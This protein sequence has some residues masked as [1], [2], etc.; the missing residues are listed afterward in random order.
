MRSPVSLPGTADTSGLET[1]IPPPPEMIVAPDVV[2]P[3]VLPTVPPRP[4]IINPPLGALPVTV[5]WDPAPSA[6]RTMP[7]VVDPMIDPASK[8]DPETLNLPLTG[9]GATTVLVEKLA[10]GIANGKMVLPPCALILSLTAISAISFSALA[11]S[12]AP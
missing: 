7:K 1:V 6:T 8:P 9:V 4:L 12:R 5:P 11:L 10:P 2:V 3:R